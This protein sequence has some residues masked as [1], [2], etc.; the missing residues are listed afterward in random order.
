VT[1]DI[2]IVAAARTAIGKLGGA[3][4]SVSAADLGAGVI[5]ACLERVNL[6]ADQVSD[7]IMG[8]VLQGGCGQNPARQAAI[9]AGLPNTVPAMTINQVPS[10]LT[11]DP[12]RR[13]R[14]ALARTP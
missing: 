8:Q 4:A 13:H 5:A 6:P 14:S 12:E 9:K 3:L 2:V 11:P 7:V 10:G 1:Q